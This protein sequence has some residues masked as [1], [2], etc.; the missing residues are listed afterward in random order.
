MLFV[1]AGYYMTLPVL[2]SDWNIK[3][4]TYCLAALF[5]DSVSSC[6]FYLFFF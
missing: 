3:L 2:F 1:L 5:S 4:Q 6:L